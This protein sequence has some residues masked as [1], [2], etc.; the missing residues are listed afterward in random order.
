MVNALD[1]IN[2]EFE[3]DLSSGDTFGVSSTSGV[4]GLYTDDAIANTFAAESP[5]AKQP[6]TDIWADFAE[7]TTD[8]T[9]AVSTGG[10]APEMLDDIPPELL[11]D[12]SREFLGDAPLADIAETSGGGAVDAPLHP[13]PKKGKK[14]GGLPKFVSNFLFYLAIV[15]LLLAAFSFSF[16]SDKPRVF[17]GYS[18]MTVVSTSMQPEIPLGSLI[19]TKEVDKDTIQIGD[20][21]TFMDFADDRVVTHKVVDI[22]ENY[23][24]VDRAFQTKGVANPEPDDDLVFAGNVVG[25]VVNTIPELGL[26]MQYISDNKIMIFVLFGLIVLASI[27]IQWFL[28]ENKKAKAMQGNAKRPR[29]WVKAAQKA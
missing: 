10:F 1:D 16:S 9:S 2:R 11:S 19:I 12:I 27:A 21:I 7:L 29:S 25:V 13:A 14:K 5:S 3:I 6:P 23:Q 26:T 4:F 22:Y 8:N 28:S 15:C 18:F 24:D 17:L 20:T